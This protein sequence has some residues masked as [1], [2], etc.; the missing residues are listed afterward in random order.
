MIFHLFPKET[1]LLRPQ[2]EKQDQYIE[3][4][5]EGVNV[6]NQPFI[7]ICDNKQKY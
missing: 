4:E 2:K 6:Y 7:I 5:E 1:V 3:D